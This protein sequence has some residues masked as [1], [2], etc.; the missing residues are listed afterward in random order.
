MQQ[1][2]HEHLL[3][4][5]QCSWCQKDEV[6][7]KQCREEEAGRGEAAAEYMFEWGRRGQRRPLKD[8]RFEQRPKGASHGMAGAFQAEQV[9][10]P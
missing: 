4:A 10:R 2:F 1:I 9:R 8:M 3:W 6:N 5:R 7:K